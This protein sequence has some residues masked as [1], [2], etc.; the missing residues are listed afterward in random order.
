MGALSS[1]RTSAL[2]AVM[3]AGMLA[4]CGASLNETAQFSATPS[5]LSATPSALSARHLNKAGDGI[6]DGR[7]EQ[8]NEYDGDR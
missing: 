2:L 1:K 8:A 5:Q 3:A 6:I 4:G 7:H